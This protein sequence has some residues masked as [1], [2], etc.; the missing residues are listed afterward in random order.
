MTYISSPIA[1]PPSSSPPEGVEPGKRKATTELPVPAKKR[2]FSKNFL[3]PKVQS[4]EKTKE[5]THPNL[6]DNTN[7]SPE[8]RGNPFEDGDPVEIAHSDSQNFK[9][10]VTALPKDQTQA[11][12]PY[13]IP[14]PPNPCEN[15]KSR[16]VISSSGKRYEIRQKETTNSI[17]YEKLIAQRS[18]APPNKAK[19]SF[20]GIEIHKI[21]KEAQE[22]KQQEAEKVADAIFESVEMPR[23][24]KKNRHTMWTEKY[25][26]RK[27]TDLVGDER[28]HRS[29]LRW[30][31]AWDPVVFGEAAKPKVKFSIHEDQSEERTHKKI[32]L[33]T[34]P[35]GLGKTTLAHVCA[36]QAGYEVVENNASDER[37]REVVKGRIRD[38][39]GTENVRGVNSKIGNQIVRKARRPVCV[40]VDEVDGVVTGSSG[41]GEG[42]F[43]KALVDLILLDQ[44]NSKASPSSSTDSKKKRKGDSFRL[45]RPM[46]LVCNDVYHPSLRPLRSS[47]LAEILHMRK[48]PLE[49][50]VLRMRTIFEKEGLQVEGDGVRRLCEATWGISSRKEG[51]NSSNAG[52]GDIRGVLVAGEWA[53]SKLR[54]FCQSNGTTPRLTRQWVE[55]H[56]ISDLAT[57]G[58]GTR[59]MGRGGV[60]E[61]V[62][63]IFLEGGGFPKSISSLSADEDQ[64]P[65]PNPFELISAPS[66]V[67][68][69]TKSISNNLLRQL[70]DTTGEHDR[71]TSDLFTTYPTRPI[72]DDTFLT[73]PN[74]AYDWLSFHDSISSRVHHHQEW[75]LAPYLPQAALAF[76]QLFAS[77]KTHSSS[78]GG[79]AHTSSHNEDPDVE[80]THPFTGPRADHEFAETHRATLATLQSLHSTLSLALHRAFRSP[81]ELATDLVPY[82]SHMLSPDVKPVIVGG[83]GENR[84]TASV[85]R[86]VERSM[87]KRSAEAM[88][89]AGIAFERVRVEEHEEG[90]P[91]RV[92]SGGGWVWRMEPYVLNFLLVSL[93]ISILIPGDGKKRE[94]MRYSQPDR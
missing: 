2:L 50:V 43:V 34:G 82:L 12:E 42:G 63:R 44:K 83:S 91:R 74:Q 62:D 39:V 60:K 54:S 93:T 3:F 8:T 58:S 28:T 38:C 51:R 4:T 87:I 55:K 79:E 5:T 30:L 46:I 47:G 18:V 23:G 19:T 1:Y 69:R 20:Y 70:I 9:S 86:E 53:A 35:P 48:P 66:S 36:K 81:Q 40:V 41:G 15:T 67:S 90:R 7:K 57:N 68:A 21:L 59:G 80:E 89:A 75:E 17:S 32:L 52:G 72:Q 25:R 73:K 11:D 27:F 71:L 10:T 37:S 16:I 13:Y 49:K 65:A 94:L 85:R 64:T 22:T 26:A 76:H 78:S 6:T 77:S 45:L 14:I 33:M 31:K 88:L 29:V 84:G 92:G 24:K 56:L 61:A